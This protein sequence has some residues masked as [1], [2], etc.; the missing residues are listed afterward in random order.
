MYILHTS[1]QVILYATTI[2]VSI[3]MYAKFRRIA[4]KFIYRVANYWIL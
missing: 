4:E 3:S 2:F 1:S